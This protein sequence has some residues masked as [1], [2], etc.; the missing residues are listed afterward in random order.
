[1]AASSE[2]PTEKRELTEFIN[3]VNYIRRQKEK[4]EPVEVTEEFLQQWREK[5]KLY[6]EE[7]KR[8]EEKSAKEIEDKY[9]S[10]VLTKLISTTYS[11]K[12]YQI[13]M[14]KPEVW[15]A[16]KRKEYDSQMSEEK[17]YAAEQIN[18]KYRMLTRG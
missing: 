3:Y 8:E 1:V 6:S 9:T 10:L 12:L 5:L 2:K 11:D 15:K 14:A 7:R 13:A 18:N 16:L 17:T 4:G